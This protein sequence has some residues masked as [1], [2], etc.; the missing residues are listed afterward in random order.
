MKA[1]A[2]N[3]PT[4]VNLAQHAFWNPGGSDI[5]HHYIQI[6]RSRITPVNSQ[7]IPTG[8]IAPVKQTPYDFSSPQTIKSRIKKLPNGYDINYVL[9]GYKGDRVL[10]KAAV[11]HEKKSGRVLEL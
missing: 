7:L 9:N 1:I 2:L 4:R 8:K 5:L 3:K 6:F 11:M 10:K